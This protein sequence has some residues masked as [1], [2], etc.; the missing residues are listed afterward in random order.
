MTRKKKQSAR[1]SRPKRSKEEWEAMKKE[2]PELAGKGYV[3][4]LK[5]NEMFERYYSGIGIVP[6]GEWDAFMGAM[7]EPLPTT[8]RVTG[9]RNQAE[10]IL[11]ILRGQYFNK[12]VSAGGSTARV[13]PKSL[14]WYPNGLAWQLDITKKQIKNDSTMKSLH[15]FLISETESGN[16]SRQEAVSMI[17]PLVM[18]IKPHH[19]IL[20]MCAAPGSKT[21]QLIEMLHSD[22][23]VPVPDGYVVA[24][25]ADNKRCYLMTHQVKR[26]Q[27]PNCMIIN[28]D[29]RIL[30]N[31]FTSKSEDA[32][33]IK[34]DRILCDVPCSG[35][36]TVRKNPDIW[37]KWHI[38]GGYNLHRIQKKILQRGLELLAVGGRLVYSTCSLNPI[39]DEA[40]ILTLIKQCA[41]A[42]E[43]VDVS[44]KLNG[45]KYCKG[46]Y[47][48]KCMSKSGVWYESEEL[49]A[50]QFVNSWDTTI[51]PPIITEAQDAK[52]ERC[53]RV[54]PH[55]QNTGAFFIAVLEKKSELPWVSARSSRKA[56]PLINKEGSKDESEKK[57]PGAEHII[58]SV[59]GRKGG[60]H[61]AKCKLCNTLL[62]G[63]NDYNS[64]RHGR[65]HKMNVENF[66]ASKNEKDTDGNSTTEKSETSQIDGAIIEMNQNGA[67]HE[68][69]LPAGEAKITASESD[70]PKGES[71]LPKS[72]SDLTKNESDLPKSKSDLPKSESD[73]IKSKSD[74]P[75]SD[76][77]VN[78][79]E[80]VGAKGDHAEKRNERE[81]SGSEPPPAKKMKTADDS[82]DDVDE[83]P[84][85]I[86]GHREDPFIFCS[87]DDPIWPAIKEFYDLEDGFGVEQI[88]YRNMKRSLYYVSKMVRSVVINNDDRVKFINLG[89]RVFS[90]A[91]S[92]LVPSCDFRLSQEG[93][94]SIAKF[95]QG[96]RLTCTRQ[97]MITILSSENPFICKL[98]P[99]AQEVAHTM[100]PG[101]AVFHFT[102]TES[103]PE[104]N[105]DIIFCGWRGKTSVRSFVDKDLRSHYLRMCGVELA[106]LQAKVKQFK[107]TKSM[108]ESSP[109]SPHGSAAGRETPLGIPS[110]DEAEVTQW[111]QGQEDQRCTEADEMEEDSESTPPELEKVSMETMDT[112]KEGEAKN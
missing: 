75:Q 77:D 89:V 13:E 23:N 110:G 48:W 79:S 12:L 50:K 33:V 103:D 42:V 38:N 52:L 102:P 59:R 108:S 70:L 76:S 49:A 96:R 67:E 94:L 35:D 61:F 58:F 51:F 37:S 60:F 101:S 66:E 72:E 53:I 31:M 57:L 107:E 21:A 90:N 45:L 99:L 18:D 1:N 40:V 65:K 100:D 88:M 93:L 92:P 87:K 112:G 26:L 63:K 29:A 83:I 106:E 62:Q 86:H 11:K 39:E 97:D 6:D 28:H 27:S 81:N 55:H 32:E 34:Y 7:R 46:T 3:L 105:V 64:H 5:K 98:S 17:P 82:D 2:N 41:G 73:L 19:K 95:V 4:A 44:D 80:S 104:P 54:L 43:L 30:P 36:G 15:G 20:D 71:D 111:N 91:P 25:D 22:D 14:P 78:K 8:F 9:S 68:S 47:S 24:N 10:Q 56:D 74:L 84:V 109:A 16:I 85:V 69:N